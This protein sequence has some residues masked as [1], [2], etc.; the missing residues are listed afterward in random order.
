MFIVCKK[1]VPIIIAIVLATIIVL[2]ILAGA[3]VFTRTA[4]TKRLVPIYNVETQSNS[5]ALTFDAS[6]GSDKTIKIMD[7]LEQYGYKG[8]FFL[9]GIWIDANPELVKEIH[10]RGHQIGNHS[11]N[12][13]HMSGLNEATIVK[14]IT[15]V[16]EKVNSITGETP[17]CFRAPFGE[18]DN[19]LINI[20][21]KQKLQCIQWNI[22]S[23]DWKGISGA[24]IT[25][26]VVPKLVSGSII[27]FH[28]NSDH[29]LDALP[30][31][32]LSV[33]NKG[34]KA[35]RVDEL[36]YKSDY[37]IDAQGKQIKNI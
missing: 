5:I 19:N 37:T 15:D 21:D 13:K 32:L 22:D 2:G 18:Y 25:E 12:H 33:K 29:I 10:R 7:I 31:I 4:A 35:V 23:L 14:E 8:T 28:N 20:L 9:T 24:Q 34:L 1:R 36:V 26:R 17:T 27:L 30:T 3:G 16:N 11:A 6:W